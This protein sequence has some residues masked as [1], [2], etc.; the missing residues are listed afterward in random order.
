MANA[1]DDAVDAVGSLGDAA[2]LVD[3][4]VRRVAADVGAPPTDLIDAA[5]RRRRARLGDGDAVLL[6]LPEPPSQ[7]GNPDWRRAMRRKRDAKQATWRAAVGQ[8]EPFDDPPERVR[9]H[10]HFRLW[11]RRDPYNLPRDLKP[12]VDALQRDLSASDSRDWRVSP[13]GTPLWPERGYIAEDD[14]AELGLITQTIDRDDRGVTLYV[15]ILD[16]GW[17]PPNR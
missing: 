2:I 15:E 9:I 7:Y 17:E 6:D 14:D 12:V 13:N 4:L 16:P 10:A 5:R 11:N 8:V 1:V 3:E